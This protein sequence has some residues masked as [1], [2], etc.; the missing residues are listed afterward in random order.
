MSFPRDIAQLPQHLKNHLLRHGLTLNRWVWHGEYRYPED[1]SRFEPERTHQRIFLLHSGSDVRFLTRHER[2]QRG[3]VYDLRQSEGVGSARPVAPPVVLNRGRVT[4]ASNQP[5]PRPPGR[6]G[7]H[8]DE[9]AR[10]WAELEL[11]YP[12]GE[13]AEPTPYSIQATTQTLSGTVGGVSSRL[14]LFDPD[15]GELR[16]E[17]GTPVPEADRQQ[18]LADLQSACDALATEQAKTEPPPGRP[19]IVTASHLI[20]T[21][22]LWPGDPATMPAELFEAGYP[23]ALLYKKAKDLWQRA[24]PNQRPVKF[25]DAYRTTYPIPKSDYGVH[26]GRA[27]GIRSALLNPAK[28]ADPMLDLIYCLDDSDSF[29]SLIELSRQLNARHPTG[30]AT[31]AALTALLYHHCQPAP[32]NQPGNH[33]PYAQTLAQI[34]GCLSQLAHWQRQQNRVFHATAQTNQRLVCT[35]P[36]PPSLPAWPSAPAPNWMELDY[37][38]SRT[39]FPP[40]T[41]LRYW[42]YDNNGE[43]LYEGDDLIPGQPQRFQLPQ[44]VNE[45]EYRFGL[46]LQGEAVH[47]FD[48]VIETLGQPVVHLYDLA[49]ILASPEGRHYEIATNTGQRSVLPAFQVELLQRAITA[50]DLPKDEDGR[51]VPNT[52]VVL[53]DKNTPFDQIR[54]EVEQQ[55]GAGLDDADWELIND[56]LTSLDEAEPKILDLTWLYSDLLFRATA[57][58]FDDPEVQA[59][60]EQLEELMAQEDEIPKDPWWLRYNTFPTPE[61]MYNSAVWKTGRDLEKRLDDLYEQQKDAGLIPYRQVNRELLAWTEEVA[62][63]VATFL[64]PVEQWAIR[65]GQ[66]LLALLRHKYFIGGAAFGA[67]AYSGDAEAGKFKK[68]DLTVIKGPLRATAAKSL[69][70]QAIDLGIHRKGV[71]APTHVNLDGGTGAARQ[72]LSGEIPAVALPAAPE[73][74]QWFRMPDGSY[75]TRRMPHYKGERL[76]YDH[77]RK[78]FFTSTKGQGN[79]GATRLKAEYAED[80]AFKEMLRE[81]HTPVRG[82]RR[83]TYGQHGIDGLFNN[84]RKPPPYIVI[85]VKYGTSRYGDTLDGRQMSDA[86]IRAK[87]RRQGSRTVQAA[88]RRGEFKKI[89][90]R[91][92]PDLGRPIQEV[93]TW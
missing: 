59:L 83:P 65:G 33:S 2:G 18:G 70:D 71:N 53:A 40:G 57:E 84:A 7:V 74:H 66:A 17:I 80:L 41:Q 91:Y 49:P 19:R 89:G 12:D 8:F 88:I 63:T 42:I 34:G 48:E 56:Q 68:P 50:L 78:E 20:N 26:L 31:E 90:V 39:P 4:T 51:L 32:A 81:G 23:L 25:R 60:T 72:R 22:T 79:P 10:V 15:K 73:G 75:N 67:G 87:I 43:L 52:Y 47:G 55:L 69:R 30:W 58:R 13:P 24:G 16:Y 82:F 54:I 6:P 45:V 35:V 27:T 46:P 77:E 64:V 76:E 9:P 11:R 86:W 93:I 3:M 61:K 28:V 62:F 29:D 37:D 85:E 38:D 44:D 5:E 1:A 21:H 92:V 14:K 36:V